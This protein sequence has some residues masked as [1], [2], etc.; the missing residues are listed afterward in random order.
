MPFKPNE[1]DEERRCL[2]DCLDLISSIN[3][4]NTTL[5]TLLKEYCEN[6]LII[7]INNIQKI[8]T[9]LTSTIKITVSY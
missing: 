1:K 9:N 6:N 7:F 2:R 4:I 8:L 5:K 3:I